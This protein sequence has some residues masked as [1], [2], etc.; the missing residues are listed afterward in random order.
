L[1]KIHVY[2]TLPYLGY[3]PIYTVTEFCILSSMGNG[4]PLRHSRVDVVVTLFNSQ[5]D[6]IF[7]FRIT[8]HNLPVHVC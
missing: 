2:L 8:M 6:S 5:H 1:I 7:N 3:R 4:C